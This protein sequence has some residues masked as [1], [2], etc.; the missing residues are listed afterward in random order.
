MRLT[1]PNVLQKW[2]DNPASV[3]TELIAYNMIR[4]YEECQRISM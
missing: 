2:D 1:P 3:Q 4:E